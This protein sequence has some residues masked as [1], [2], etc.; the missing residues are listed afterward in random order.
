MTQFLYQ[1]ESLRY[2]FIPR[3]LFL[4]KFCLVYSIGLSSARTDWE[5][6]SD[7]EIQVRW[8]NEKDVEALANRFQQT[9]QR[10][11]EG[12]SAVVAM[13]DGRLVGTAWIARA[14]YRDW[15][16]G[17][18]L[19]LRKDHAWLYGAWV[20]REFRRQRVYRRIFEFLARHLHGDN[21]QEIRLAVD[22]SNGISRRVHE[23][24]GGR[25]IGSLYG[26]RLLGIGGFRF[27]LYSS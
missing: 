6:K 15:E 10:L 9:H 27:R 14:Q 16:T 20:H 17:L 7:S 23:R 8:S 3:Q 2:R 1:L 26:L 22:W 18:V 12:D 19:P 4:P 13:H 25:V 5:L 24:L 21:V 11:G